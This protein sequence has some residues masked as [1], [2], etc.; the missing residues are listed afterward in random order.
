MMMGLEEMLTQSQQLLLLV[1]VGESQHTLLAQQAVPETAGSFN[2]IQ[3]LGRA[4]LGFGL[5]LAA[6]VFVWGAMMLPRGSEDPQKLSKA[7]NTMIFSVL[8]ATLWAIGYFL[9]GQVL[10]FASD[11]LGGST[12]QAGELGIVKPTTV[13]ERMES[14]FLGV[15]NNESIFCK[16]GE[17][18]NSP[19]V[20]SSKQ[21]DDT[22]V[23][24]LGWTWRPEVAKTLA[25]PSGKPARCTKRR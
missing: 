16:G 20:G 6:G 8:G 24:H 22:P 17:T 13:M 3:I 1:P 21:A 9:I 12:V 7:R 18:V 19:A 2:L 11:S 4:M 5:V 25:A 14:E 10:A 23:Q 15:Y